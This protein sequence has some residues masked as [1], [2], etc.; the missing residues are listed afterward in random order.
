MLISGFYALQAFG[1]TKRLVPLTEDAALD[2]IDDAETPDGAMGTFSLS[3]AS[4]TEKQSEITSRKARLLRIGLRFTYAAILLLSLSLFWVV[5]LHSLPRPVAVPDG[6][7][8]DSIGP[9]GQGQGP[10]AVSSAGHG[11]R[12]RAAADLLVALR[13]IPIEAKT[14]CV[15]PEDSL[16]DTN[17]R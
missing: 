6:D 12:G 10:L 15:L 9:D 16:H 2:A 3:L 17:T 1:P 13:S 5:I 11:G 14:F 8:A 4:A 7:Q